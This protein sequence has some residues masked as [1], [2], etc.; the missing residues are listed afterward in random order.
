MR[1]L[2]DLG[3]IGF[4]LFL[5]TVNVY[6]AASQSVT[7]DEATTY[8]WFA[9]KSW[10]HVFHEYDANHHI[11]H[12]ILVKLSTG[13]F[14]LSS[15][16][17]R[18]PSLAGGA[19][20]LAGCLTLSR[21][22]F[23]RT[24]LGG[25]ALLALTINPYILD[26]LSC[27]RGYGL[28][29]AF[30]L[31]GLRFASR[32]EPGDGWRAGIAFGLS[33]GSHLSVAAPLAGMLLWIAG[34]DLH[35]G[36]C[37]ELIGLSLTFAVTSLSLWFGPAAQVRPEHFYLGVP[38]AWESFE[39]MYQI[40]ITGDQAAPALIPWLPHGPLAAAAAI[41]GILLSG[42]VLF[43][44]GKR[45]PRLALVL[46]GLAGA[47]VVIAGMHYVRGTPWPWGRA[48]LFF[49]V[50]IPL[51][52]LLV[53]ERTSRWL[54]APLALVLVHFALQFR[55]HFYID[56]PEHAPI[57]EIVS[58][59]E[60]ARPPGMASVSGNWV[61]AQALEYHRLQR[62]LPWMKPVVREQPP[63]RG[64]HFYV[65]ARSEDEAAAQLGLQVSYR[66]PFS[67]TFLAIP[68]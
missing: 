51:L 13:A 34:R 29:L 65:F 30:L 61:F 16:A 50:L 32:G 35:S 18:L 17:L 55:T 1:F 62:G 20:Y 33:L 24:W 21:N 59:M 31:W 58:R 47:I 22:W 56:W 6:R 67:G 60:A 11:L 54:A 38:T 57:S 8:L 37:R 23:G 53:A 9:G 15:L 26:F 39:S 68:K 4:V 7:I 36:R 40:V 66:D 63:V 25:A 46:F 42:L 52:W 64:H 2:W 5:L 45:D 28:A 27:A 10:Y 14:G 49:L 44:R 19:L 41:G 48:L 3:S 12:T 43:R